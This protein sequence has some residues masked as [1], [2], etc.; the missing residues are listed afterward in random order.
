MGLNVEVLERSA[1]KSMFAHATLSE[2]KKKLLA[3]LVL[4]IQN[5]RRIEILGP[6]LK[7]MSARHAD[8][9]T[10]PAHDGAVAD[11]L[12]GVMAEMAWTRLDCRGEASLDRCIEYDHTHHAGGRPRCGHASSG[13]NP[14]RNEN[15][16]G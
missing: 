9:G 7:Q 15:G 2:Q 4:V 10:Q 1:V 3:S 8:Y 11:T 14:R 5:L 6:S 12:L 13:V 16:K